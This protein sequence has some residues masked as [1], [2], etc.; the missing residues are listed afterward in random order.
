VLILLAVILALLVGLDRLG[1]F[2]FQADDFDRYH[3]HAFTVASVIDGDTLDLDVRDGRHDTTR[4][5]LW[6]VDTPEVHTDGGGPDHFGPEA[7]EFARRLVEGRL[8]RVELVPNRSTR[9][10]HGR[11]LAYIY[12]ADGSMLNQRLIAEGYAYADLRFEHPRMNRF[13]LVEKRAERAGL[14]LWKE[15]RRDQWPKWRQR[16]IRTADIP[17]TGDEP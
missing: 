11:L 4:V 7:T 15:V 10:I 2:G 13:R 14:G 3:D 12:L 1:L 16:M 8:V 6:G 9:G 5:R 17:T